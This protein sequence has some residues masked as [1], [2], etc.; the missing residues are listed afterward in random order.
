MTRFARPVSALAHLGNECRVLAINQR[1][2]GCQAI[3]GEVMLFG[4]KVHGA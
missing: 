1:F 4:Q 2:I 3:W